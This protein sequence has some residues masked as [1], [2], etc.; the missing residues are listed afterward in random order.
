MNKRKQAFLQKT[1]AHCQDALGLPGFV[2]KGGA[3]IPPENKVHKYHEKHEGLLL[4]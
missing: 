3:Q 1:G 2:N 4:Q